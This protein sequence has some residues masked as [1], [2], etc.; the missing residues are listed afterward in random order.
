LSNVL[1]PAHFDSIP[2]LLVFTC[3]FLKTS[4]VGSLLY[5]PNAYSD[6]DCT[7]GG[8]NALFY[9]KWLGAYIFPTGACIIFM[10]MALI[11]HSVLAQKKKSDQ[12][13]LG[14][15][16]NADSNSAWGSEIRVLSPHRFL[17]RQPIHS[18][19]VVCWLWR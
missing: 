15:G 6:V 11:I 5:Q 16:A 3:N 19:T 9:R 7:R 12:N 18:I 4:Y 1:L 10:N 14:A 2:T 17:C 8:K 13:R